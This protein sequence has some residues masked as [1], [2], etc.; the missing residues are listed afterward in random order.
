[1]SGLSNASSERSH[2][3]NAVKRK[4]KAS[5]FS[6]DVFI[7]SDDVEIVEEVGRGS[8]GVVYRAV[9]HDTVVCVKHLIEAANISDEEAFFREF[10]QE[11]S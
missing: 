7:H 11:V 9:W 1:M 4:Q 2:R 10:S 6:K 5:G 3:F 8:F